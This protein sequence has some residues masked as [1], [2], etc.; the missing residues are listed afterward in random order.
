MP[1]ESYDVVIQQV[2]GPNGLALLLTGGD[3]PQEG[4]DAPTEQ[5][6]VSTQYPGS[7]KK[8]TQNMGVAEGDIVLTGHFRDEHAGIEGWA[9]AQVKKARSLVAQGYACEL[10]W[11]PYLVRRG[12]LREV[13]PTFLR[14]FDIGYR[15]VFHVSESEESEVAL[16]EIEAETTQL[17]V[18]ELL[19]DLVAQGEDVLAALAALKT[20]LQ[21]VR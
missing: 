11:G 17:D 4:L 10:V 18:L 7:S 21:A 13:T 8:S 14:P 1:L 19:R 2:A 15:L 12:H 3:L 16:R 20:I 5:R 9:L 6:L